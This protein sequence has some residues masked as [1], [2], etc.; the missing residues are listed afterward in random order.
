MTVA[1]GLVCANGVVVAS[2]SMSTSGGIAQKGQKLNALASLPLVWTG[3]GS[4]YV[5]EDVAVKLKELDDEAGTDPALRNAFVKPDLDAVRANLGRYVREAMAACYTAATPGQQMLQGPGG[6]QR[7]PFASDFLLL[8]YGDEGP[9]FLEVSH[10]GQLNWHHAERFYAVGSG[11]EFAS[12]AHALMAHY[13]EG[14]P[15]PVDLGLDV[16]YRTIATTIEV[17][18]Q[19]VGFPVQLAVADKD[20]ARVLESDDVEQVKE[21]VQSWIK[22]EADTLRRPA[23]KQPLEEP[24]SL[25]EESPG[26]P[27]SKKKR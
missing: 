8:G 11:G 5:I 14:E 25:E 10:D 20:G 9:Y 6:E 16:A 13:L 3:S 12:V 24:P 4:V 27:K 22:V 23:L 2:D 19:W 21:A 15:L 7:H 26:P 18:S 17:S 1:I